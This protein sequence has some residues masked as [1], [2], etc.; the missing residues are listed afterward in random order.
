HF[1]DEKILLLLSSP[2]LGDVPGDFCCADDLAFS[3]LDGRNGQRNLDQTSIF[4]LANGFI[5]I[6]TLTAPNARK[7]IGFLAAAIHWNQEYDRLAD[8][9][10]CRIA[11]EPLCSWVPGFNDPIDVLTQD[12]IIRGLDD[13][14]E[15]PRHLLGA[16]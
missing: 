1:S 5:V 6:D 11:E 4:A 10:F 9:F 12:G 14:S 13:C 15:A 8:N 3:I 16:L 7:N 2:A